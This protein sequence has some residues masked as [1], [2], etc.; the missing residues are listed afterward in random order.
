MS[1]GIVVTVGNSRQLFSVFFSSKDFPCG[2]RRIC[3][4]F[5]VDIIAQN[6]FF[7]GYCYAN[8]KF[9]TFHF[10]FEEGG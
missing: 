5:V 6:S 9:I 7:T 8:A 4:G 2:L 1:D 10:E 3:Y